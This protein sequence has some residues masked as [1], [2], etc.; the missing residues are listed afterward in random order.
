MVNILIIAELVFGEDEDTVVYAT[1]AKVRYLNRCGNECQLNGQTYRVQVIL[2][3][4]SRNVT[5]ANLEF[6]TLAISS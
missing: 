5:Y 1:T 4:E 6:F 3:D 2:A